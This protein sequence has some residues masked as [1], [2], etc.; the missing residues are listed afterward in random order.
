MVVLE[1]LVGVVVVVAEIVSSSSSSR[2]SCT[3]K[4]SRSC[5]RACM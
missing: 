1:V 3:C 2:T 4:S 5:G